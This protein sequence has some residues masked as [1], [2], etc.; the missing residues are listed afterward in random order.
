MSPIIHRSPRISGTSRVRRIWI[1]PATLSERCED[2]LHVLLWQVT[3]ETEVFIRDE[4]LTL[5]A[6]FAV[7]VPSGFRH[8]FTV[9]PDS[10]M[11]PLFFRADDVAT[12][13]D[14]PSLIPVDRELRDVMLAF[15]VSSHTA[16]RTEADLARQLFALLE[17]PAEEPSQ[18]PMPAQEPARAIA[19]TLRLNPGDTRSVDGLAASAHTSTRTLERSFLSQTGMT[20]RQWRIRHRMEAAAALL[21]SAETTLD[22]VAHRVGYTHVN[23]FRR[24]FKQHFGITAVE[25]IRNYGKQ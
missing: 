25:Y 20:L 3:G 23:A 11:I 17:E 24:V 16:V 5:S 19:E 2:L 9:R 13:L 1:P 22:A 18:L 6:D 15:S 8:R 7:W 12:T 10:V 21:R 4:P 14:Q